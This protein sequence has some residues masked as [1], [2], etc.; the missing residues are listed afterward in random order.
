MRGGGREGERKEPRGCSSLQL[1]CIAQLSFRFRDDVR[2]VFLD[3][4]QRAGGE[5]ERAGADA[6]GMA[7][8]LVRQSLQARPMS[9]TCLGRRAASHRGQQGQEA[10]TWFAL[11]VERPHQR[12]HFRRRERSKSPSFQRDRQSGQRLLGVK[13]V[14]HADEAAPTGR[15]GG[16]EGTAGT[17][18]LGHH[19]REQ[20]EDARGCVWGKGAA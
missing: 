16:V 11:V 3:G 9:S 12:C 20:L 6:R 1:V 7:C 18:V 17:A 5:G 13:H 4:R 10:R 8:A 2:P 19:E 14:A 15:V